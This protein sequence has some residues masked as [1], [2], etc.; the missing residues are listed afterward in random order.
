MSLAMIDAAGERMSN[1]RP[2]QKLRLVFRVSKGAQLKYFA[3]GGK[4]IVE[5]KP[6]MPVP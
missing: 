6:P 5:F 3:V 1:S 2:D 4:A